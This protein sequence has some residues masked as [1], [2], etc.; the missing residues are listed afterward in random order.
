VSIC[1]FAGFVGNIV[2]TNN[3][4]EIVT[5]PDLVREKIFQE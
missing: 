2:F 4:R 5:S 3:G 1:G